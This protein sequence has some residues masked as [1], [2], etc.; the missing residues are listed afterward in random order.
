MSELLLS[1][2]LGTT[3]LKVAAFAP[4][5]TLQHLV[6]VRHEEHRRRYPEGERR[7]QVAEQWWD[8][9][10]AGIREVL[11]RADAPRVL[12]IG[13]SGRGGA[14][15]FADESGEV[16]ADP[17]SD[18]RHRLQDAG[19]RT[20][21]RTQNVQLANA[22]L[23]L[24]AK[25]LWLEEQHPEATGS[26]V[27]G[28]FAK[29]WLAFRLTGNHVTDWTS[30]PDGAAWDPGL[31][32]LGIPATLLP[33]PALPWELA[34]GLTEEAAARLGLDAGLPVAV[35]AHD[36]LAANIGAGATEPGVF[37]ITLGTHAV[38]RAVEDEPPSGAYRFYG[39]PP[40][41]HVIGGNAILAGR[42]ADWFVDLVG[43]AG[44]DGVRD[45]ARLEDPAR[46]VPIGAEGARFLPFLG[47]QVAPELR[48]NARAVF[49]GLGLGHGPEV[50]YRAVLEGAAFAV[51]GIFDQI[52]GWC[53][54]PVTVRV[55][56]GGAE[57]ALWMDIL[58]NVLDQPLELTGRA[59]E[60]RGAAM[61][62]AVA[63]GMH[64]DL[65]AAV[66]AMVRVETRVEP[67]A[68]QAAEY[69]SVYADW[70]RLNGLSRDFDPVP[71][72]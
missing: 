40:A 7:W 59:A 28:F 70:S 11:E 58:A 26:I 51:R 36:G 62:L 41:R 17:W 53:G 8:D 49:A 63:L 33:R 3:R 19:L 12:G 18:N 71:T 72:P 68:G 55:T 30:G 66:E 67:E 2:D 34:G 16:I 24:I 64:D 46:R 27:R 42:S 21:R 48:P 9:A 32:E 43:A 69:G 61:C 22:G 65:A 29:D 60:A 38:V 52:S 50:L 23:G 45:Y 54:P 15:V 1:I 57:S 10:V 44:A 14:A 20:W 47:G 4:D 37:A 5:G 39:F 35:G 25:Y 6:V 31:D 13:L 56:G